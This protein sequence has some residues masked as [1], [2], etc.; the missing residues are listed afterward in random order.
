MTMQ[1]Q[2]LPIHEIEKDLINAAR[3]GG[4]RIVL[5]APTGSGKSTQVPQM[6]VDHGLVPP[7]KSVVILQPRRLAARLL[8]TRVA[9]ERDGTTGG[10][11]GYQIRFEDHTSAATRIVY[12][13]EGILLRRL[14]SDPLLPRAAVLVFDE[15]HERHLFGDIT[16]ARALQLQQTTR[17]DLTLVVMSATLD[18]IAVEKYLAPCTVLKAEGRPYPVRLEY[19]AKPVDPT[20]VPVWTLAAEAAADL[21]KSEPEGDVLIFMPGAYEIQRTLKAL[22][23]QAATRH[24]A[25]LPLH[26]E[27]SPRDQDAAVSPCG[28]RKIIVSTN[29]AETSLTI[30]GV[31]LV[32]DGGLA[33]VARF[34][35]YRGIDTLWIEKIS[36]ASAE[37]RA[38]RAGRTAP[39]VCR[40]LWTERE[41]AERPLRDLPEIKRVDLA[42]TVLMLKAGGATDLQAFPWFEVPDSRTLDRAETLLKDLGAVDEESGAVTPIG[43]R[44]LAFPI[45]PRYARMMLAAE[46][47]GCVR[48]MAL[49]AALTQERNLLL[50]RVDQA[51][52][53]QRERKLGEE[54]QSDLFLLM[55]AWDEARGRDFDVDYCRQ[56]GIHAGT[57]RQAG[58][59]YEMFCRIAAG[60][61]LPLE[62][63]PRADDRVR[64]CLLAGFADQVARRLDG[65][66]LRCELVHGR[67][68]VLERAS[69]V[70]KSPFLVV[71]EVREVEAG[72]GRDKDVLLSLATA[73][74]PAWLEELFAGA[75]REET[76][77]R[78][79][80]SRRVVAERGRYYHDMV[81]EVKRGGTPPPDAAA[82]LLADEI[83]A[84]RCELRHWNEDVEQWLLR[85]RALRQWC[86]ELELP[87]LTSDDR[88]LMWEELC[89]GAMSVKDVKDRPVMPVVKS[90]LNGRQLA[91][92]D[93]LAPDRIELPGGRRVKVVYSENKPPMVAVRIQDLYEVRDS[94]RI[95]KGRQV[96][97][98]QVLAPNFRPVQITSDLTTFWKDSYPKVKK[99][100]QRKYPK[101]EWR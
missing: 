74:E 59:L 54:E 77:V 85:I 20:R 37:Q 81:L 90:R 14:V 51:V 64:R 99:E 55:R 35:P 39:G 27:L 1:T 86:P 19:L 32:I 93:Q 15:F 79:D 29:V 96:V 76:R 65:G 70:R 34:D 66:T 61:D 26:G 83:Q 11:V 16:L 8:A 3:G 36:R 44:M 46:P 94:L 52:D 7:G 45:H 58:R 82:R 42:E 60:E 50:K 47:L 4:R 98:I 67:R 48:S 75:V 73:I 24:C 6:L 38:G 57:A 25:L 69:V 97:V 13:T 22:G 17:P 21:V 56:L 95:A 63:A 40:R 53:V 80:D 68:G 43:A 101:H 18:S 88:R 41:Q 31:R 92:L 89:Q 72:G 91:L 87:E 100:L 30:E 71:A 62:A 84:G 12:V 33:R 49:I 5:Q 28:R 2:R 78:L 10:E 9:A 23:D